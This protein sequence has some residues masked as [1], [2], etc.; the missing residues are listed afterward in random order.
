LNYRR[1][2]KSAEVIVILT[3]P[4]LKPPWRPFA[5]VGAFFVF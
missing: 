3:F 1:V 2:L 5:S 4:N